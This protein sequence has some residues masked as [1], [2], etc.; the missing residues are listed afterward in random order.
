MP[1]KEDKRIYTFSQE[2]PYMAVI[3]MGLPLVAGMF[4]MVLYNW[5]D[6]YFI[7]LTKDDYQLAAVDLS[8]PV[9]MAVSIMLLLRF[10]D[11][12]NDE[13]NY[14]GSNHE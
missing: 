12:I 11:R 9:T 6:T 1:D 8:Y 5:V 2:T 13:S 10:I 3:K 4:I 7:G 14:G